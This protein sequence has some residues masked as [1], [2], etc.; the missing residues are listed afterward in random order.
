[1]SWQNNPRQ[2]I[3]L[4]IRFVRMNLAGKR[5]YPVA[6][7]LVSTGYSAGIGLRRLGGI[8]LRMPEFFGLVV[9]RDRSLKE[10]FC[11]TL[12]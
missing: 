4:S 9:C 8:G 6:C 2:S 1:L 5:N 3:F 12:A 7:A 10:L 11:S